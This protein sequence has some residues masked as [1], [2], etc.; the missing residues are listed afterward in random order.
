MVFWVFFLLCVAKAQGPTLG[1]AERYKEQKCLQRTSTRA[2]RVEVAA[3]VFNRLT[4]R[5]HLTEQGLAVW[6]ADA[7]KA[8]TVS[9][10][11]LIAPTVI[12]IH[13]QRSK[14]TGTSSPS[15]LH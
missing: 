10:G 13:E 12:S 15:Q 3:Q 5:Q 1:R 8:E 7:A 4:S 14:T 9:G 11:I 2:G 6:Q